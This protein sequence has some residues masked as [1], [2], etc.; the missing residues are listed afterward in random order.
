[1]ACASC[2]F[3][4]LTAS[5]ECV[6]ETWYLAMLRLHQGNSRLA[7]LACFTALATHVTCHVTALPFS[8]AAA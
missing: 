2:A 5:G 8:C 4:G 3:L 6:I 7:T 1:M